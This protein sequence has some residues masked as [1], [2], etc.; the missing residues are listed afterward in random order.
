MIAKPNARLALTV[1]ILVATSSALAADNS[2]MALFQKHCASC[3]GAVTDGRIATQR[4]LSF[5]NPLAL[6]AA[7]ETGA[8][9][10]QAAALSA[11]DK[12][13]L[14]EGLTGKALTELT[15]PETAFCEARRAPVAAGSTRYWSGWGGDARG[16]GFTDARRAGLAKQDMPRL[17]L[18]WAFAF[19]GVSQ[20][21]SQPAVLDDVVYVGGAEGSVWALD[22]A[23]G[24]V[25]WRRHTNA[26]VR[27]AIAVGTINGIDDPVVFAVAASTD[28]YALDAVT[29]AELWRTRAGSHPFHS[30]TGTPALHDG[31]LF[32]PLSSIE[33]GVA[34]MPTHECCVSAGGVVALAVEDGT[35]LWRFRSTLQPAKQVGVSAGKAVFA[36]SG[37]PIWASPTVDAARGLLYVGTGENY[38]RPATATSDAILALAMATGELVWGFQATDDDAWHS[39]CDRMPDYAPCDAPGPDLDFG[40]APIVAQLAGGREVLLAGQKSAE[41]FALDPDDGGAVLWRTRV[42]KGGALGGVH[43]GM[44]TDGR[45]VYVTNAD[46]PAII[47]DV[48]P[49]TAPAPGVYALDAATGKVAWRVPSPGPSCAPDPSQSAAAQR[50]ALGVCL[51]GHSAAPTALPGVVLAGDL[52]G[53]LRAHDAQTGAE[54]WAYDTFREFE[55]RNGV[56][57]RGGSIDGPGPVV[58]NGRVFVN[59]GYGSFRQRAG[60]VLLAFEPAPA[61]D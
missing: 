20:A 31:R 58:A 28:V 11:G 47:K 40:M 37:A 4:Q 3:H 32:V 60:N 21:R 14:A 23:S 45:R 30:V 1:L 34:R 41:V 49:Q 50:A 57:A 61:S 43:W 59:S 35:V 33:V 54:L 48:N 16:T 24:C 25:Y 18:A 42:G 26:A 10:V 52:Y 6:L 19:P 22:A 53:M 15:V 39:G 27:G 46:R 12:R 55:A 2:G 36:P 51:T 56:P 38:S 9:R 13:A 8:M 17:Q 44:A 29:G 5:M 7:M